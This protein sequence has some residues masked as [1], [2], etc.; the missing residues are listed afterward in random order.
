MR[1][2]GPYVSAP[3]LL[4]SAEPAF[5]VT[6]RAYDAQKRNINPELGCPGPKAR[7]RS[8]APRADPLNIES[9]R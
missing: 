1:M 2:N 6:A 8:G 9:R 4:K 3:T 5:R 7:H